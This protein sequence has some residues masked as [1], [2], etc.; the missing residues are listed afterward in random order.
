[1]HNYVGYYKSW[2]FTIEDGTYRVNV[3]RKP[4]IVMAFHSGYLNFC[5]HCNILVVMCLLMRIFDRFYM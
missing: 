3:L 2:K 5:P 4:Q 1:M